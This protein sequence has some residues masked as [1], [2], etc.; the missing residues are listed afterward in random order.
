MTTTQ[1]PL[2]PY[3]GAAPAAPT[4]TSREAAEAIRPRVG[5]WQRRVLQAL[6][7]QPGLTDEGLERVLGC[8]AT[9]TSRPRR[10]ELALAGLVADSGERVMGSAGVHHICWVLTAAGEAELLSPVP[11]TRSTPSVS[12]AMER[13]SGGLNK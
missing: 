11:A 8:V 3:A 2:L 1:L 6:H 7:D 10:R 12:A 9:R 13:G 4:D 5:N